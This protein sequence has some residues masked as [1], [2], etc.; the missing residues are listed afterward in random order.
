MMWYG[1]GPGGWGWLLGTVMMVV[2]WGGLIALAVWAVRSLGRS[3]GPDRPSG[4]SPDA[5]AILEERFARGEI[6][7]EEFERRRAV[8]RGEHETE[9]V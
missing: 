6:D 7:Q 2:F 1:W 4:H 8:L 9:R 3:A 5:I